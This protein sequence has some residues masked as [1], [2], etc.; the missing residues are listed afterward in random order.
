MQIESNGT[1]SRAKDTE[2]IEDQ[3]STIQKQ[4]PKS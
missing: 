4:G 1:A 3:K 2:R